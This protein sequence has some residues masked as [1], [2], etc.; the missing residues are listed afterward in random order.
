MDGAGELKLLRPG[1]G[2]TGLCILFCYQFDNYLRNTYNN[3]TLCRVEGGG[4]CKWWQ[5]ASHVSHGLGR[6]CSFTTIRD[7]P[8]QGNFACA[9]NDRPGRI[10]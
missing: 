4:N 7:R 9:R 3:N 10:L 8:P 1:I 5:A 2:D 6:S